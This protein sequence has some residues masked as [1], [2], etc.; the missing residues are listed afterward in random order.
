MTEQTPIER[1]PV[2]IEAEQQVLGAIL[3]AADADKAE[4]RVDVVAQHGG[5]KIFHDPVHNLIYAELSQRAR[6]G[7]ACDAPAMSL[8]AR[9]QPSLKDLGGA[10]YLVKLALSSIATSQLAAYCSHLADMAARRTLLIALDS[11]RDELSNDTARVEHIASNLEAEL[12]TIDNPGRRRPI[13]MLG[14]THKAIADLVAAQSG[15]RGGCIH[16]GLPA[17]DGLFSGF[18]PGELVLLGGRPSMGKTALALSL[19]LNAA[20]KG[21]GVGIF[22]LE[23]NPDQM[24][25]RA[26][27]EQTT[28][29]G[30][31]AVEYQSIRRGDLVEQQ[32][33]SVTEAAKMVGDLPIQF[34]SREYADLGG[35]YSG[36]RRAKSMLGGNM[37][38][39]IVDYVQLIRSTAKSRYEQITEISIALKALAGRLEVPI[40]ALSQLSRAVEQRDDKRPMLS[41]LR[42]SG[43]LE[44]DADA[45]MF[46]YRDEYY[47]SRAEPTD[48]MDAHEAWQ[49]AMKRAENRLEVI[50][51]KQRQG[52]VGTAHLRC[53]VALNKVWDERDR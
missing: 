51:A 25:V 48:D 9:E 14:A 34:L 46:T 53:N 32:M 52:Q 22:S 39:L 50:V 24:A 26:L 21:D 35:L 45:V 40:L 16:T 42:E 8:W 5:R 33:R 27:S 30:L 29:M 41:D 36:A 38:L 31:G 10:E 20:R 13:S 12:S 19:A 17:L 28:H 47:L 18:W 2:S 37:K 15:E 11:A 1:T 23:M 3:I 4:E 49:G 6:D 7:I 43:Q 44:Q